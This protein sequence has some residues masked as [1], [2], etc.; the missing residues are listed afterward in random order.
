MFDFLLQGAC[1]TILSIRVYYVMCPAVVAGFAMFADT[2][3]G[4]EV[5]SIVQRDGRCI[6][7]AAPVGG[8]GAGTRLPS[9]LCKAD[10]GWY[11]LSGGCQCLPGY[12]PV[13]RNG[14]ARCVGKLE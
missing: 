8:N 10:G 4:P 5:A 7:N 3:S 6:E 9:Y 14:T 11:F 2:P 13:T 1:A 12:E